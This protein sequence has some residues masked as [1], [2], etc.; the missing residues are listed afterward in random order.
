MRSVSGIA[1][2]TSKVLATAIAILVS[3]AQFSPA[4]AQA[5]SAADR[6]AQIGRVVDGLNSP[7]PATRLT[8]LEQ[9]LASTDRNL[10]NVAVT[11][12]F[13]SS[14]AVLRSAALGATIASAPTFVVDV[15]QSGQGG[16]PSAARAIGKS[17]EVRLVRFNRARNTFE[18]SSG[19]L[20]RAGEYS[21]RQQGAVAGDRLSFSVVL[22]QAA[23]YCSG[24]ARLDVGA[25][26]RG[27]M[28]CTRTD[29][30][31]ATQENYSITIDALR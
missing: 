31:G 20:T 30:G 26:L 23:R 2:R 8:T 4:S 1:K 14:D 18:T 19:S 24:V 27:S 3:S 22:S 28:N 12:A 29:L 5:H 15:D 11:T 7:D 25:K 16:E 6:R 10:R 9:A 13:A 21:F 17:F